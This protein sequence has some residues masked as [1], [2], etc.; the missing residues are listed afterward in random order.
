[1]SDHKA[2]SLVSLAGPHM[3]VFGQ[4]WLK[5]AGP[6]LESQIPM[7]QLPVSPFSLPIPGLSSIFSAAQGEFYRVAYTSAAQHTSSLA[8]LWHDPTHEKEYLHGNEFLPPIN[9][10]VGSYQDLA[11]RRANFLRLQKAAFFVGSFHER[12]YDSPLGLEP[13]QTGIFGF[14]ADG[15]QSE[16]VPLEKQD[17]FIKDTFGLKT[18][19]E[20]GRLHLEAVPGVS[21]QTW[22]TSKDIFTKHVMP[23]L[24]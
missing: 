6:F 22:L 9:G 19:Q 2:V 7:P 23:H 15:S 14:Y 10:E 11:H 17:I 5:N 20:T 12:T 1:M 16:I 13:W 8:N 18:L 4:T 24:L 3:G 21:H